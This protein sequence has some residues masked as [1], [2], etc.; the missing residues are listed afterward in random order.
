MLFP[1]HQRAT[2][3]VAGPRSNSINGYIVAVA[4]KGMDDM[5][6]MPDSVDRS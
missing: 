1:Q 4:K 2:V 3:A 5:G 6:D